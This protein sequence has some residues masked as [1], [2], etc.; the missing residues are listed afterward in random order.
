MKNRVL[1]KLL[2][3]SDHFH[4]LE[5]KDIELTEEE[6]NLWADLTLLIEKNK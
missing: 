5:M 6:D 1:D 4:E 2:E 3:V